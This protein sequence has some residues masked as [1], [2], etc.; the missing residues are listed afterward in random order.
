MAFF[1]VKNTLTGT[2]DQG[3]YASAQTGSFPTGTGGYATISAALAATTPPTAG[4]VICCSDTHSHNYATSTTLTIPDGVT[5]TSVDDTSCDDELAGAYEYVQFGSHDLSLTSSAG[6]VHYHRGMKYMS[7]DNITLSSTN[8]SS[9]IFKNCTIG[10]LGTNANDIISAGQDGVK[11]IFK[12]TDI[13]LPDSATLSAGFQIYGGAHISITGGSLILGGSNNPNHIFYGGGAGG[14]YLDVNGFDATLIDSAGAICSF[15]AS[16]E[17]NQLAI[18]KNVLMP[19]GASLATSAMAKNGQRIEG[20]SCGSADEYY[21]LQIED[22]YGSVTTETT[23]VRTGAALYDGTNEK[24]YL[25]TPTQANC[26]NGVAGLRFRLGGKYADLATANQTVTVYVMIDN[27]SQ[28]ATA[29]TDH[30]L[31]LRIKVTDDTNEAFGNIVETGGTSILK[32]ATALPTD[33]SGS[34]NWEGEDAGAYAKYYAITYD[35]GAFTNVTNGFVEVEVEV[36]ADSLH[37]DDEL[38][39]CPDFTITNT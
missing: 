22:Y 12:N 7:G 14:G 15:D 34:S 11:I 37:A 31:I 16:S 4:D 18:L 1:Y 27:T 29:L 17:D 32:T 39:V 8:E 6:S 33:A 20:Y 3:R 36:M 19:A 5:V 35:L 28:A 26:I 21:Q 25:V 30:D 2:G 13:Q 38:Y 24:S 9:G 10:C 23:K